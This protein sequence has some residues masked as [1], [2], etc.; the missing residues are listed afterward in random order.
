MTQAAETCLTQTLHNFPL[1]SPSHF[2]TSAGLVSTTTTTTA[3]SSPSQSSTSGKKCAQCDTRN[4]PCWRRGFEGTTL[5]NACGLK[6]SRRRNQNAVDDGPL[7]AN[8]PLW[9]CEEWAHMQVPKDSFSKLSS[10]ARPGRDAPKSPR[11]RDG[12]DLSQH[13]SQTTAPSP[14]PSHPVPKAE[15]SN[16]GLPALELF[17]GLQFMKPR[18]GPRGERKSRNTKAKIKIDTAQVRKVKSEMT[19][20]GE[21]EMSSKEDGQGKGDKRKRQET[22]LVADDGHTNHISVLLSYLDTYRDHL[23]PVLT[24]DPTILDH[25]TAQRLLCTTEGSEDRSALSL[26][27]NLALALGAILR[28][29]EKSHMEF[30]TR[31]R[32]FLGHLFDT[33]NYSVALALVVMSHHA[34]YWEGDAKR[35]EYYLTLVTNIVTQLGAFHSDGYHRCLAMQSATLRNE[36]SDLTKMAKL[37]QDLRRAKES[38]YYPISRSSLTPVPPDMLRNLQF[39]TAATGILTSVVAGINLFKAISSEMG[40]IMPQQRT[41][42]QKLTTALEDLEKDMQNLNGPDV[43]PEAT[44]L[45]I[46][47]IVTALRAECHMCLEEYNTALQYAKRFLRDSRKSHFRYVIGGVVL[48]AETIMN[49][50]LRTNQLVDLAAQLDAIK[51]NWVICPTLDFIISKYTKYL[52]DHEIRHTTHDLDRTGHTSISSPECVLAQ[53][54][55]FP[56]PFHSFLK[57]EPVRSPEGVD[58]FIMDV[59]DD[60]SQGGPREF[61]DTGSQWLT[62]HPRQM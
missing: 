30:Y 36:Q 44:A 39:V 37:K 7:D 54:Q 5:C 47:G 61:R 53:Q 25:S 52:M 45:T 32:E 29:D 28:G 41:V 56:L 14:L 50:F 57:Q 10:L 22:S 58:H 35:T 46:L 11:Q 31:A 9:T 12:S 51:H 27:L 16:N 60:P 4:T 26:S 23:W 24:L 33:T 1:T 38:P 21:Q 43:L 17:S 13:Q 3:F 2:A 48:M 59:A 34:M 62:E 15:A 6:F 18:G 42:F 49:V 19:N 8:K 20:G 55:A 40:P